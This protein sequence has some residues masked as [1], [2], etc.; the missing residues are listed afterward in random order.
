MFEI[1]Y[2]TRGEHFFENLFHFYII[3]SKLELMN[4]E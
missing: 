4:E 1:K 2:N 3:I